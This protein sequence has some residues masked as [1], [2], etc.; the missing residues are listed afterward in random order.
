MAVMSSGSFGFSVSIAKSVIP[1]A[2][3]SDDKAVA[4]REAE[5][6]TVAIGL[7]AVG[8]T[9]TDEIAEASMSKLCSAP[10]VG[11]ALAADLREAARNLRN[12]ITKSEMVRGMQKANELDE[13]LTR[14]KRPK[15]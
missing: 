5:A 10:A 6:K 14:R 2:D 1:E 11:P 13:K 3:I 9:S 8:L 7:G 15:G 12:Q 4:A